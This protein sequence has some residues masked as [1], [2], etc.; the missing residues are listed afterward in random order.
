M[1]SASSTPRRDAL[2]D[3]DDGDDDGRLRIS[4]SVLF[5]VL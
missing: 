3:D 2:D 4:R 1:G 5:A